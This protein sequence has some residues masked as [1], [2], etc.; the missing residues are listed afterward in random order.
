MVAK[1]WGNARAPGGRCGRGSRGYSGQQMGT[2]VVVTQFF[3]FFFSRA[4]FRWLGIV[5]RVVRRWPL[6]RYV[7]GPALLALGNCLNPFVTRKFFSPL[8]SLA[9]QYRHHH[10]K[11][12]HEGVHH[13]R[14]GPGPD[15]RVGHLDRRGAQG[16]APRRLPATGRRPALRPCQDLHHPPGLEFFFFLFLLLVSDLCHIGGDCG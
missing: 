13:C 7:V 5:A 1:R 4:R 9:V 15:L 8:A 10:K 14:P 6:S 2:E 16:V 11:E 3:F 12:E